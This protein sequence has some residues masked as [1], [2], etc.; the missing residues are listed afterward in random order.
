MEEARGRRF[1]ELLA[2]YGADSVW[3]DAEG[4]DVTVR[5][6]GDTP[7]YAPGIGDDTRGLVVVLAVLRAMEEARIETDHDIV[8]VGVVGKEGPGRPARH[9]THLPRPGRGPGGGDSV[10]RGR[11]GGLP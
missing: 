5:Q 11:G 6:R 8:F 4:T 2:E 10:G 9:E 7:C 3:T 1:A